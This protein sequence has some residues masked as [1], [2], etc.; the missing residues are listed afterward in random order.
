MSEET[1]GVIRDWLEDAGMP[2]GD[3]VCTCMH[4]GKEFIG[5]RLRVLCKVC[6]EQN[7]SGVKPVITRHDLNDT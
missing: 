4:C 1:A 5:Y 3:T 7:P 6:S 2:N